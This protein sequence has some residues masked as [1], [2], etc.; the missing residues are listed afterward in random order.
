MI[1]TVSTRIHSRAWLPASMGLV[2]CML[3]SNGALAQDGPA[4]PA[5]KLGESSASSTGHQP[6]IQQQFL[7]VESS[8]WLPYGWR[9][10]KDG[11]TVGA[12]WFSVVPDEAVSGSKEALVHA[13]HARIYQGFT[14][15]S[16]LAGAGLIIGG[17]AVADSHRE[18]TR[19][20]RLLT[21]GGVLA[22]F[23]EFACALG[24]EDEIMKSVNAYNYDLVRGKLGE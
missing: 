8:P 10:S 11:Q 5:P 21:A 12:A 23:T 13:R 19:T 20:A 4:A 22:I 16:V 1:E 18:W 24:R 3:L 6:G 17:L 9:L 2:W 7:R 14:L 15:G